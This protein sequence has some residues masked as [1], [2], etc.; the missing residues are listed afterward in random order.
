MRPF[1]EANPDL[2]KKV[3]SVYQDFIKATIER[4]ADVKAAIAKLYPNLDRAT[5]DMLF[6]IEAIGWNAKPATPA[7][8]TKEIGL[9]KRE[10]HRN[11]R[12]GQGRPSR[13]DL[14]II[15]RCRRM[16]GASL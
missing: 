2:V 3:D 4:R 13:R 10:R 14:E 11:A 8:V 9:I 15:E 5:I 6:E 16:R 7:D 1:A 12:T